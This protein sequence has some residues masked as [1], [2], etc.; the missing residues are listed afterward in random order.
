MVQRRNESSRRKKMSEMMWKRNG[1]GVINDKNAEPYRH[2][3][4]E[5]RVK[6]GGR[7]KG[8]K[9]IKKTE[10]FIHKVRK[11][12]NIVKMECGSICAQLKFN[13]N[14]PDDCYIPIQSNLVAK[15]LSF[16]RFYE[17]KFVCICYVKRNE[18]EEGER[19]ERVNEWS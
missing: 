7:K 3:I 6:V 9:Q 2:W 14:E 10:L 13:A 17:L 18:E 12:F 8:R 4:T 19:G 11:S 15:W 5:R 16:W 1:I